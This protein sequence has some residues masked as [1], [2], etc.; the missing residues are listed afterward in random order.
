MKADLRTAKGKELKDSFS[1]SKRWSISSAREIMELGA[2][3]LLDNDQA[4]RLERQE[5]IRCFYKGVIAGSAFTNYTCKCCNKEFS[6]HC[7]AIP[8]FCPQCA[9]D[10][11]ICQRCGSE[12]YLP[13][14]L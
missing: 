1:D 13:H 7:T 10:N 12:L 11:N 9:R 4:D 5:C 14:E 2:K 8:D 6:Y 3:M